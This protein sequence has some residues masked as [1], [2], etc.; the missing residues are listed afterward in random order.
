L[1]VLILPATLTADEARDTLSMLSQALEREPHGTVV[2]DAS[3]L[4]RFDSAA[5]ALLL[6]IKRLALSFDRPF[7]LRDPPARLVSLAAVYGVDSVI[8]LTADA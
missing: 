6:E 4:T 7:E 3:A 5:L 1:S 2:V 8:G